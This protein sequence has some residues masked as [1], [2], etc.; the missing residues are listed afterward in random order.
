MPRDTKIVGDGAKQ[1]HVGDRFIHN[2]ASWYDA[3]QSHDE[4]DVSGALVKHHFRLHVV[5]TEHLTVIRDVDDERVGRQVQLL[6]LVEQ[7]AHHFVVLC[8]HSIVV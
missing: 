2:L 6:K 5:V 1:G 8:N 4:R 7:N 3:R